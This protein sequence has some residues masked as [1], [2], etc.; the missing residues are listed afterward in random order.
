VVGQ[1]GN[2]YVV[3]ETEDGFVL[4]DPHAAHERV[5]FERFMSDV[6]NGDV[7]SQSLLMP[8]TAELGPGD[9]ARVRKHLK[10]LKEMGFGLSEFGGDAFVVDALPPYFSDARAD[11]LLVEVSSSL[12]RAGSRGGTE[13]WREESIAQA[14]CTSAVKARDR[15]TLEEI[16]QL[17][18]DLAR[19]EM[20][21]TC[22]HGRPT[23]IFTSFKELG[24]KFGR[25]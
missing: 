12:D 25:E 8:Q 11:T 15:L 10:L 13:R 4:M 5:L 18:V 22:P 16:E 21:Y 9:A 6:L 17:V 23:L 2:L 14:A 20:P 1:I 3:L 24:R 7:H 19:A